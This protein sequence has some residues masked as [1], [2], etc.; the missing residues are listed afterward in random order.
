LFTC[1]DIYQ[2]FYLPGNTINQRGDHI[3]SCPKEANVYES[4]VIYRDAKREGLKMKGKSA[5]AITDPI[6][7]AHFASNRRMQL[8]N[9]TQLCKAVNMARYFVLF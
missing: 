6:I 5:K 7:A 4:L 9:R 3:I 2:Y 1:F 8:V